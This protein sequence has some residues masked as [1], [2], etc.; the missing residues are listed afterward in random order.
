MTSLKLRFDL[1]THV[2]M[3]AVMGLP[4][5]FG[6]CGGGTA[7]P[8]TDED[9]QV[10]AV[11][12]AVNDAA[13]DEEAFKDMFVGG[14]A[15][16]GREKYYSVAIELVSVDVS[17]DEATATVTISQSGAEAEG[18][19]ATKTEDVGTGEVAWTLKKDGGHWKLQ[20]A[21]LP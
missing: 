1:I 18:K 7:T 19:G 2:L 14:S 16:E 13:G 5:F 10:S 15:P 8:G 20:D 21:P 4:M 11:V 9:Q 17:G 12:T 3:F 6:G